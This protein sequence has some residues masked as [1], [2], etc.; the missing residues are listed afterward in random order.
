MIILTG[1]GPYGK[2]KTNLSGQIVEKL[3]LS[4]LDF[5]VKKKVF[6]VIWNT[7]LRSL[8]N[9]ITQD[10]SNLKLI[11]LLGIHESKRFNIEK[12]GW[13]IVFG[14][15][16]KGKFKFGL[17]QYNTPFLL[18]TT[19]NVNKF[20]SKLQLKEIKQISFSNYPGI[21]LCNYLY[22]WALLLSEKK[23]PVVFIHIPY[24]IELNTGVK[25]I[26]NL[27][28]AIISTHLDMN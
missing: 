7:S 17:I 18:K 26:E 23:Y 19:L 8:K 13:N 2:N 16:I 15:D 21:Y 27:I 24:K 4:N 20:Y 5:P 10:I 3:D 9:I 28:K 22:Y 25:V 6:P 1:F 12:F 14:K 11:I